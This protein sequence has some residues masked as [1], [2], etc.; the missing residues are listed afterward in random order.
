MRLSTV[1]NDWYTWQLTVRAGDSQIPRVLA[2]LNLLRHG[3]A[4]GGS[5][6]PNAR[7]AILY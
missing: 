4:K 5:A 2:I 3:I 6:N 1:N 7:Q